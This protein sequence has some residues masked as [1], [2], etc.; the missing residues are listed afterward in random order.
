MPHTRSPYTLIARSSCRRLWIVHR[1]DVLAIHDVIYPRLAGL[2]HPLRLVLQEDRSVVRQIRWSPSIVELT[3]VSGTS[4][5]AT[6]TQC[7]DR[8]GAEHILHTL[9]ERLIIS[10]KLRQI[11]N[12]MGKVLDRPIGKVAAGQ[13]GELRR[14]IALEGHNRGRAR[15]RN[16]LIEKSHPHW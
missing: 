5:R 1:I 11:L 10:I 3:G 7:W 13:I 14:A 4:S 15:A 12:D 9:T 8:V 16:L 6:V 2:R